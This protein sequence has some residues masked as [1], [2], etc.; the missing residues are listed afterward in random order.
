MNISW[1]PLGIHQARGFPSYR[2]TILQEGT[3]LKSTTTNDS[4]VV[5]GELNNNRLHTVTV[6]LI[7]GGGE[8]QQSEPGTWLYT[9]NL[10]NFHTYFL[11]SSDLWIPNSYSSSKQHLGYCFH[12]DSYS[13]NSDLSDHCHCRVA[14]VCVSHCIHIHAVHT[15]HSLVIQKYIPSIKVEIRMKP[16]F[17][18]L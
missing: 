4:S 5:I 9:I 10:N 8:G 17:F 12:C 3:P 14:L 11:S 15:V 13:P 6:Q 1:I 18:I 2:V 7:T 16:S